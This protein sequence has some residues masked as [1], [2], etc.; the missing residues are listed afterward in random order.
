MALLLCS[1]D[2]L[3]L[4]GIDDFRPNIGRQGN[5]LTCPFHTESKQTYFMVIPLTI[6]NVISLL[7]IT[8]AA[9]NV[10]KRSAT[11]NVTGYT[12]LSSEKD[13]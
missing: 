10:Y 12:R 11:E 1:I 5:Q 3:P 2:N 7:F 9:I 8:L 6:V 13:R 4:P